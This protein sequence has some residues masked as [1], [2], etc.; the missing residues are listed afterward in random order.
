MTNQQESAYVAPEDP[1]LDQFEEVERRVRKMRDNYENP[2][3]V[4]VIG[5]GRVPVQWDGHAASA[6]LQEVEQLKL[7]INE[8]H[9]VTAA[10]PVNL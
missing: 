4:N 3:Y 5:E 7:L 6:L 9:G 8:S 1:I 2:K 10:P